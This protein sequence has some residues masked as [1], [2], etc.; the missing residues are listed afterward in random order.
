VAHLADLDQVVGADDGG[1]LG[2][3]LPVPPGED[4]VDRDARLMQDVG[5]RL[6]RR[7]R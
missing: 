5:E 6:T 3:Q 7:G 2:H 4:G 1:L